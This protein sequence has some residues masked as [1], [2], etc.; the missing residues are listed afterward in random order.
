M[1]VGGDPIKRYYSNGYFQSA[2]DNYMFSGQNAN[3]NAGNLKEMADGKVVACGALNGGNGYDDFGLVLFSPD[4]HVIGTDRR[5][6]FT[7]ND[8]CNSLLVQ[9]DGK[10][11]LVGTV[12][13]TQQ[14]PRSFL[15]M[16][17]TGFTL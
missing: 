1:S 4:G 5:D 17:Y 10:V 2:F 6:F 7:A 15:V 9:P 12:Q 3:F 8:W 16:R 13:T 11:V 14:G